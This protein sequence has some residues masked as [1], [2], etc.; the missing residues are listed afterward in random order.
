MKKA[1]LFGMMMMFSFTSCNDWLELYPENAQVSSQ[2]WETKADV[3]AVL[4]AGYV[5]LRGSVDELFVWGE[6]RGNGIML[7]HVNKNDDTRASQKI[8]NMDIL[9]SNPYAKWGKMYEV[10]NIANSVIKY[11]PEVVE[12]DDSFTNQE[13]NSFLSEAY[14]L[15]SLAYFYLVRT[16][17]DVPYITQPYVNDDEEFEFEKT[18]GDLILNYLVDDLKNSM[19]AAKEFFPE[20]D[21]EN[22]MNTKGRATKWAINALLADIY[23]W[24]GNYEAC[25]S[26]CDE[27]I[28]SG[29]VGLIS[30]WFLNFF[31]GNSNESIFEIQ[32]SYDRGQTNGFAGWFDVSPRYLASMPTVQVFHESQGAGDVRGFNGSITS[33]LDIWKYMGLDYYNVSTAKRSSIQNDQNFIVY[34]LADVLLMKA[35]ALVMIGDFE[36][37]VGILNQI[38]SRAGIVIE[39]DPAA[40]EFEMLQLVMKERHREL[41][42][43][44]KR[45][46]DLLRVA[47]RDDYRYLSY[48][49]EEVTSVLPLSS[50]AIVSSK[51]MNTDSHYL[52]IHQDELNANQL[53]IQNPYYSNLGN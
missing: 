36:D 34:R 41:L 46:F 21:N 51:L 50:L 20:V 47:K 10:I 48:L 27:I 31:P 42:A 29:R 16:F 8:R 52:P 49:I 38:R 39:L 24:Q 9:P 11:G 37:A 26:A 30:N 4:S 40:T 33:R 23:L 6:V 35:E 3:E 53:L 32:Y 15:R 44:G 14:F 28:A 1:V 45:W 19:A 2:Y 22:P 13:L 7:F 25:I 17:R 5:R 18:S 12:K 43:E